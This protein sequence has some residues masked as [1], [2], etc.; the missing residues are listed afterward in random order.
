MNLKDRIGEFQVEIDNILLQKVNLPVKE[1]DKDKIVEV[2]GKFRYYTITENYNDSTD[3]HISV[4]S[5]TDEIIKA[6]K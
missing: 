1:I 2:L 5:L 3:M 6:L 4:S